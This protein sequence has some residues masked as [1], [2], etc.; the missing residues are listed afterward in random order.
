[1]GMGSGVSVSERI[2]TP[3]IDRL[4]IDGI[5]FKRAAFVDSCRMR[6]LDQ[7]MPYVK[8]KEKR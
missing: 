3:W 1:M 8:W 4:R 2:A 5:T 6:S 7:N